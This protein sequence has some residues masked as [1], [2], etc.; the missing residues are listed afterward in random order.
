MEVAQGSGSAQISFLHSSK[1]YIKSQ[2]V[3]TLL[4]LREMF[5][6]GLFCL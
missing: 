6:V 5:T 3:G 1:G 4:I 2:N